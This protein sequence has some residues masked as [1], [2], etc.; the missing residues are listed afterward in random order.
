VVVSTGA[1]GGRLGPDAMP[2]ARAVAGRGAVVGLREAQGTV[3]VGDAEEAVWVTAVDPAGIGTVVR[4]DLVRGRTDVAGGVLLSLDYAERLGVD[5]GD[6]LAL[7]VGEETRAVAVRLPVTGVYRDSEV[8]FGALIAESAVAAALPERY[9]AIYLGPAAGTTTAALRA[10]TRQ[11]FAGQPDAVVTDVDGLLDDLT[12][13][14]DLDFALLYGLLGAVILVAVAGVVNTM[15]LAVLERTGEIGVLRALGA[16]RRWVGRVVR[17]E[18]LLLCGAGGLLA[19][20]VG[21]PLGAVFQHLLL[22]RPL[23]KLTVPWP[24]MAAVSGGVLL[25][26]LLAAAWPARRAAATDPLAAIAAGE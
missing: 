22:D 13:G 26:A 20:A 15:V 5:V 2:A 24:M 16:S 3:R 12:A 4:P 7:R 23:W 9:R 11:A 21:L 19:L 6:T 1:S 8:F 10:A 25:V 18:A 17:C 14:V